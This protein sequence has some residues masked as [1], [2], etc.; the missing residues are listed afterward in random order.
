VRAF[1]A[2]LLTRVRIPYHAAARFLLQGDRAWGLIAARGHLLNIVVVG[3]G[4]ADDQ[5]FW[6]LLDT[7]EPD[8]HAALGRSDIE[9]VSV[10]FALDSGFWQLP[11][12][13]SYARGSEESAL[14]LRSAGPVTME[15]VPAYVD[16]EWR[17]CGVL[18]QPQGLTQLRIAG[19]SINAAQTVVVP[20]PIAA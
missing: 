11:T 13:K 3:G 7:I 5:M 10:P 9:R 12:L 6:Q 2:R 14:V 17:E 8:G 19:A 18:Q 16:G 1:S 4:L 15:T 20:L